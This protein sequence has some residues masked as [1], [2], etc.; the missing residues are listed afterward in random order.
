MDSIEELRGR[1]DHPKWPVRNQAVKSCSKDVRPQSLDLLLDTVADRRPAVWWRRWLGDPFFQVGFTR[2]N[3]WLA[4]GHRRCPLN[5]F[6]HLLE[7]GL[8]DPYYEVRVAIWKTLTIAAREENITWEAWA[9]ELRASLKKAWIRETHFEIVSAGLEAAVH[10]LKPEE[11]LALGDGVQKNRHWRVRG[12]YL[13]ALRYSVKLELCTAKTISDHIQNFN[14]RS[15]YFRPVFSLKEVGA[16]L[17]ES[18]T[19][20]TTHSIR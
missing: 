12:A 11:L 17:T 3:A 10:L 2:R 1:L 14:Y 7:D 13:E 19:Q 8:K 4:L 5:M 9:P 6:Q 16:E 15:D 20:Q 18:L